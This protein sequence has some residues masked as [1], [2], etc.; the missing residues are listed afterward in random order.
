MNAITVSSRHDLFLSVV[1]F[2]LSTIFTWLF[3]VT[4][5]LYISHEQMLLSSSIA[6]GKWAIQIVLA[7][8][9][10]QNKSWVFIRNI[11]FVCFVGSCILLPYAVMR[12]FSIGPEPVYFTGSL[13]AAVV[14]MILFY[15][16]AT[17]QAG[18]KIT[19]W[20]IWLIC[21]AIAVT[22]QLTVVFHVI[23]F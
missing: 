23:K 4:S 12:A 22:L 6:G 3:V 16:R 9:L 8:A 5:P 13:I 17:L 7:I 15:Y 21:L 2:G 20:F 19:W 18:V 10:L 1:Y 11:G 14:T